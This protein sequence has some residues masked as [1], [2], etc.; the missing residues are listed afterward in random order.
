M[1]L[2]CDSI[3]IGVTKQQSTFGAALHGM[4]SKNPQSRR[5]ELICEPR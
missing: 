2:I 1:N 3:G 5:D 4:R